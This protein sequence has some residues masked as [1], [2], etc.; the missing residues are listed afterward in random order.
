M[1]AVKGK[2]MARWGQVVAIA[3]VW[4]VWS[5]TGPWA[6]ERGSTALSPTRVARRY[7]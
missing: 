5:S 7:E 4:V 2:G 1:V 3:K 6:L